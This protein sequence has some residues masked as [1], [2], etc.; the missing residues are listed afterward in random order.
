M[1]NIVWR[2]RRKREQEEEEE[3]ERGKKEEGSWC[4]RLPATAS[5][6]STLAI[7][8]QV[9]GC[10]GAM[11]L[12]VA[13]GRVVFG[14]WTPLLS[15]LNDVENISCVSM[16]ALIMSI[17]SSF[18]LRKMLT[19]LLLTIQLS[20]NYHFVRSQVHRKQTQT[21]GSLLYAKSLSRLC[22]GAPKIVIHIH[23]VQSC[24]Y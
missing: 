3:E 23:D 17:V 5:P 13:G 8:P 11:W 14:R 16:Q 10:G 15:K 20:D 22:Q 12:S 24:R 21:A 7:S 1:R 9:I 6:A 19:Q 2:R 18:C 4:M